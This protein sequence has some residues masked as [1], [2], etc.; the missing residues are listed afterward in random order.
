MPSRPRRRALL[1]TALSAAALVAAPTSATAAPLPWDV[2]TS[3]AVHP[4][5][6]SVTVPGS[7]HTAVE[8][9]SAYQVGT[10]QCDP[11][12]ITLRGY[13]RVYHPGMP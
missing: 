6:W 5:T 2:T 4:L 9:T 11:V 1:V 8:V 10:G 12:R 7:G 3:S 13:G